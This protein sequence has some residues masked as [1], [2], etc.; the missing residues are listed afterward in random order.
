MSLGNASFAL[1][2][3]TATTTS[4]EAVPRNTNRRYLLIQNNGGVTIYVRFGSAHSGSEGV[5]IAAG[6]NFEPN[7]VP[8]DAVYVRSATSTALVSI[9]EGL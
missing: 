7:V 9:Y 1:T 3:H 4:T 5:W 8:V 2:T 6:G